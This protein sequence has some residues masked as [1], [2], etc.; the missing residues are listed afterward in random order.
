MINAVT[1]QSFWLGTYDAKTEK[2]T[3]ADDS[4]SWIDIGGGGGA[5]SGG[6]AHWAATSN[7][8]ETRPAAA[9]NR[10]LWTAWVSAAGRGNADAL[11]MAREMAWDRTASRLVSYPVPEY[12]LLRNETVVEGLNLGAISPGEVISL[13]G[14]SEE[15]GGALDLEVSFDLSNIPVEVSVAHF[16]VVVRAPAKG[17]SDALSG[18]AQNVWF[19]VG[20]ANFKGVRNVTVSGIVNGPGAPNPPQPYSCHRNVCPSNVTQ[21]F[22]LE[23]LDV[24]IIVDRPIVEVYV[25]GGRIAWVHMDNTFNPNTTAVHI[26]NAGDLFNVTA[27]NVSAYGMGCGWRP[28]LPRP[29]SESR[30]TF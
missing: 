15:V 11:A 14:I 2:F 23:T 6:A 30:G 3:L 22:P 10:L 27:S 13:D 24:R 28:D 19:D 7:S 18:A 8:F 4:P 1:G 12:K 25:L 26:Y 16:G 17:S 9:D 5:F 29:K 20:P 21:L